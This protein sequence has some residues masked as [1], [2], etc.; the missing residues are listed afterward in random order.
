MPGGYRI[1]PAHGLV[2]VEYE[3]FATLA[4][5]RGLYG[6]YMAA[7]E[8]RPEQKQLINLARIDDWERD[9]VGL[10]QFQADAAA[11]I[12]VEEQSMMMVIHAAPGPSMKLA[13]HFVDAW[14]DVAGMVV[15]LQTDEAAALS[16]LGLRE[17]SIAELLHSV[18]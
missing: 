18:A 16:I 7:P 9:L 3:G 15:T 8:R 1:L 13:R 4:D 17:E 10:M 5:A 11:G 6:A 2:Y 14:S 12:Y